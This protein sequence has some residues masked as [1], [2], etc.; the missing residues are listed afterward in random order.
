MP[1]R[2]SIR[3]LA[4][5]LAL[6]LALF[7]G[8]AAPPAPA[9]AATDTASAMAS[10]VLAWLNQDRASAGLVPL[11]TWPSLTSIASA[12]A[13]NLAASGILSHAAA[14][15]DPGAAITAAG[16]QWYGFGEIIGES[17]YPWGTQAAQNLYSMWKDSPSHHS[18]MFSGGYNYVGAGFARRSDG[19]TWS[20]ILF[21]ESADHTSPG[22]RNTAVARAGATVSFAWSGA[23]PRLQ[24]HTAGLRS[25]DVQYRVDGGAWHLIRNDTAALHLSLANR[26]HGHWYSFRVQAADRRGNLS[27]WTSVIRIWVP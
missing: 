22:A 6:V 24:T 26:P 15:G 25:F 14:G 4:V 11:R 10:Q 19:T 3:P 5:A 2:P 20:S 9:A 12:R 17:G 8:P 13:A 16:L 7:A 18:I 27:R 23:D 1:V 21:T